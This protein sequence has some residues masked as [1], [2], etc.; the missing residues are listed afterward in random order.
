MILK[1]TKTIAKTT[2]VPSSLS[3]K[4][5]YDKN[6]PN[7]GTVNLYMLTLPTPLCLSNIVHME[8]AAADIN[9]KYSNNHMF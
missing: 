7:I 6:V 8:K 3:F 2:L 1:D 9:A 5:I 4:N